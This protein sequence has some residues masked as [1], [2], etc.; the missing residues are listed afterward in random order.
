M[1]KLLI[2]TEATSHLWGHTAIWW[3]KE[4]PAGEFR[5]AFLPGEL[6]ACALLTGLLPLSHAGVRGQEAGCR[7]NER[8]HFRSAFTR[9]GTSLLHKRM[10]RRSITATK[11]V[12]YQIKVANVQNNMIFLHF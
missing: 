7:G 4:R 6:A 1:K 12:Y 5:S 8:S 10:K 3:L 2:Y 11:N 9:I